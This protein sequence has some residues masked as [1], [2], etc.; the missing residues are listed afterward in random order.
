M[1]QYLDS[2]IGW[3]VQAILWVQSAANP[4]LDTV[5]TVFTTMG[6]QPFYVGVIVAVYWCLNKGLARPLSLFFLFSGYANSVLKDVYNLP[7]PYEVD[8]RIR[9]PVPETTPSFPSGHAQAAFAFWYYLS[10]R[11]RRRWM[12]LLSTALIL[13]ISFSRIYLGVHFPQDIIGGWII[14]FILL[15]LYGWVRRWKFPRKVRFS[16]GIKL[17]L[18][19]TVPLAL[20]LFHATESTAKLAGLAIGLA[21]GY[22]LEQHLIRFTVL[23]AWWKRVLRFLAGIIPLGALYFGL[24]LVFPAGSEFQALRHALV[25]LWGA[26]GAPWLFAAAR[27]AERQK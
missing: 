6:L 15:V 14:G 13:L 26:A 5:F 2:L 19:V 12:W 23:G 22:E 17:V 9:A 3:G 1:A 7:R 8:A 24:A 11:V 16:L 18:A 10:S 20:L 21:A 25:G 27:L 4:V